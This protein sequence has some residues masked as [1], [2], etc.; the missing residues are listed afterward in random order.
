MRRNF[1]WSGKNYSSRIWTN[2]RKLA[3]EVKSTMLQAIHRGYSIQRLSKNLSE[4]MGVAYKNAERLVLTE[5]NAVE[6]R[7]SAAA[8]KEADF[9]N[10]QYCA[11]M[12]RRTCARCGELDGEI[13]P[14]SAMN[15]GEN[16]PPL[17]P[18]CRCTIV[19][20]FDSPGKRGK[21][22]GERAARDENGRRTRVPADMTY[23]DWKA[24]YIDKTKTFD[25]WQKEMDTKYA[26]MPPTREQ[27]RGREIIDKLSSGA[28]LTSI[29]PNDKVATRGLAAGNHS[30]DFAEGG[31]SPRLIGNIDPKDV[32]LVKQA[33]NWFESI[34]VNAPVE[35]AMIITT[36]GDVY[37]CSGDLNTLQT[38]EDLGEKLHGA[39]VTH[40]HP[41][42][43]VNDYSFSNAD[44]NLFIDFE[45]V[46][47][48]GIDEKFV[49]EFNRN[50]E[51][52]DDIVPLEKA[53][54]FSSRH[55]VVVALAKELRIGYRRW[56][57]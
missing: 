56:A 41:R 47:L 11:A 34:A 36:T 35:N 55:G 17:H 19:A 31:K 30:I 25:A 57:R 20:T 15:Q 37:H 5:L 2:T 9:E 38:I 3:G 29:K 45:L 50:A 48:R 4:R 51:D 49:Y 23:K 18:R 27:L 13:F 22:S 54:K 16:A 14:L 7:A 24:V 21:T 28:P 12:D 39:I 40:N 42:D 46:R 32:A 8:M 44:K 53:N 1:A 10:Y 26:A 52:I 6:N 43:S 33:L